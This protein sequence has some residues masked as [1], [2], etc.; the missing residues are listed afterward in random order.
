MAAARIP[1]TAGGELLTK[2]EGVNMTT[3]YNYDELGNLL[4]V[5]LPDSTRIDYL[6]DGKNRRIGK[7]TNETPVRD[8]MY[9]DLLKPIAKLD[10]ENKVV[11]R[12]VYGTKPNV[13]DYMMK[14]GEIY[15]IISDHLGSPRLVVNTNRRHCCPAHGTMTA[16]GTVIN[17]TN[18]GFQPF[19]F[20]G[21]SV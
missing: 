19:G 11:S 6:I 2:T 15:R 9:K 21:G 8:F 12:F 3:T 5:T 7:K 17:D 10:G 14:G 20:A 18:P 1:Y 4:S 16:F 13:P